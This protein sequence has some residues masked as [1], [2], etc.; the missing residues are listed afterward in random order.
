MEF[1]REGEKGSLGINFF[2]LWG[3]SFNTSKREHWI[4]LYCTTSIMVITTLGRDYRELDVLG[5]VVS[6]SV[7]KNLN[8]VSILVE[9]STHFTIHVS[10]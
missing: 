6:S 4:F 9:E 1:T 7:L 10:I 3:F 2:P 5:P 8:F